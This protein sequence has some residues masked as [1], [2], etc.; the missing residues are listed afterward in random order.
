MAFAFEKLFVYQ[1]AFDFSDRI[2]ELSGNF[3]RGFYFPTGQIN[4]AALS[5][6][7]KAM[8]AS[9][10]RTS[11]ISLASCEQRFKNMGHY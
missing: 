8:D 10:R 1:N 3:P 9:P 6:S 2:C 5:I 7:T 4:R 11:E